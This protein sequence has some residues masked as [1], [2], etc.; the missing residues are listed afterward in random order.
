MKTVIVFVEGFYGLTN[1]ALERDLFSKWIDATRPIIA[2]SYVHLEGTLY[3]GGKICYR[4]I[5]KEISG[6]RM[7]KDKVKKTLLDIL[8]SELLEFSVEYQSWRLQN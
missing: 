4:Q 7:S 8:L 2:I 3:S 1:S 6:L 5:N